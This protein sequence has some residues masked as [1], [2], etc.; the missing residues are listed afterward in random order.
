MRGRTGYRLAYLALVAGLLWACA[1]RAAEA[2]NTDSA[3]LALPD[4]NKPI[5]AASNE[6]SAPSDTVAP[7]SAP[8]APAPGPQTPAAPSSRAA[9]T[10]DEITHGRTVYNRACVM[11]HGANGAG[12]PGGPPRLAGLKDVA[13]MKRAIAAGGAN[14]PPMSGLLTADEIDDAA[15]FTAAGFPPE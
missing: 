4:P 11:C 10:P 5:A 13:A 6:T 1:P 9:A 3:A 12:I 8:T 15:K 14:M 7:A 2:P